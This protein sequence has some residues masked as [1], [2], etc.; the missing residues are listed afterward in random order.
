MAADSTLVF[1]EAQNVFGNGTTVASTNWID[2]QV[3]QNWG[4]GRGPIVEI[5]VTTSF[6]GGTSAWFQLTAVDASGAN[7]IVLDET[8]SISLADLAAPPA[9]PASTP[10]MGGSIH[11]LRMR[12]RKDLPPSDRTHLRLQVVN[13]GNNTAGAITARLLPEAGTSSPNKAYPAGY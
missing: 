12:P 7:P 9:T 1:A 3:A 10:Q 13:F 8:A 4:D 6:A 11:H 2:M 5:I